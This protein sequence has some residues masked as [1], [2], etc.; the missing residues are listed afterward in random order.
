MDPIVKKGLIVLLAWGGIALWPQLARAEWYETWYPQ[1]YGPP[2]V[3]YRWL[4]R[5][6]YHLH[7]PP[8]YHVYER[9]S[10]S[11]RRPEYRYEAKFPGGREYEYKVETKRDGIR[12]QEDWDD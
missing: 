6:Y 2:V 8:P 5:P 11:P 4:N 3:E 10:G 1:Q 9:W 12:I 7:A